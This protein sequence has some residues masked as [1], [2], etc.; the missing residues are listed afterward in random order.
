MKQENQERE[1][2]PLISPIHPSSFRLHPF[3]KEVLS[4]RLKSQFLVSAGL[5]KRER[6]SAG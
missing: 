3:L 6:S 1:S 2:F 4:C 5:W